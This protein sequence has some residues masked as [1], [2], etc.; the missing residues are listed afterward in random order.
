MTRRKGKTEQIDLKEL[1][2]CDEDFLQALLQAALEA[3]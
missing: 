2:E 1:V 3:R